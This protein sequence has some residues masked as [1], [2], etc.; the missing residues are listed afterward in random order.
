MTMESVTEMV[1]KNIKDI[2]SASRERTQENNNTFTLGPI[3][4]DPRP[5]LK[6]KK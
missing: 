4:D 6:K 1:N 2:K 3:D 5:S